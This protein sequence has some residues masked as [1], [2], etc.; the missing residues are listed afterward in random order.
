[1]RQSTE[2]RPLPSLPLGGYQELSVLV[3]GAAPDASAERNG[4]PDCGFTYLEGT[5]QGEDLRN[6]ACV[7]A[8]TLN[9]AVGL[10]R[11]RLRSYG[12]GVVREASEPRDYDVEV[13]VTGEA[14]RKP[15]PAL[16]KAVAKVTF[17]VLAVP[18]HGTLVSNIDRDAAASAFDVVSRNCGLQNA[19][20]SVFTASS[21][22]PMTPEFDIVTLT[23]EA[24]DNLL[25][26][27]DLAK[28]FLEARQRFPHAKAPKDPELGPSP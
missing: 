26:C 7:P 3:R 4:S 21:T 27:Y 5:D 1:M 12:I 22:Q 11:Q 2:M 19:N 24:V 18:G 17:K 23:G 16:A 14:P 25:R 6:A 8:E 10:V 13:S 9:T 20:L 28:F 15:N